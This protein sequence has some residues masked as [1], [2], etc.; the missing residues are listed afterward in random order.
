MVGGRGQQSTFAMPHT[1][2][3]YAWYIALLSTTGFAFVSGKFP[4]RSTAVALLVANETTILVI[5]DHHWRSVQT[6]VI[7]VDL[8]LL[9]F[10]L[11]TALCTN[12]WWPL[13]ATA[14]QVIATVIA[15]L[16]AIVPVIRPYAYYVSMVGWDY[17]TLGALAL[18][19]ALEGHRSTISSMRLQR[20]HEPDSVG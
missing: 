8:F 6:G 2:A 4:E 10:L 16:P 1:F 12:R 18:G 5:H 3:Q 17:L 7:A 20:L 9:A 14:F 11:W 19:T 13:F 15:L